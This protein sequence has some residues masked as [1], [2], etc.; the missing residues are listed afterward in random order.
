MTIFLLLIGQKARNLDCDWFIQLSDNRCRGPQSNFE[1][2]GG[3]TVSDLILGG[4]GTGHLF[5]LF[6]ILKILGG[7]GVCAPQSPLL[8]GHWVCNIKAAFCYW[9][10]S[11]IIILPKVKDNI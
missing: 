10:L 11:Y 3:G 7:W 9:A 8:R 4:G 6:I 1:I 5:L 2:G